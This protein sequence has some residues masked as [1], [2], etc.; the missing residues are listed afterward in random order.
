M[1]KGVIFDF[2]G[3]IVDTEKF[4]YQ[5]F[6]NALKPFGIGYSWQEYVKYYIGFDDRDAFKES[7]KANRLALPD[8]MLLD[9]IE[10]K[11]ENFKKI[12]L[13][14]VVSYP[15]VIDLVTSL[16]ENIPIAICSG[17]LYTDIEPI[18]KGLGI[19]N[20]FSCVISAENVAVSKPDPTSYKLALKSLQK[21]FPDKLIASNNIVAIEDT[22]AG[23]ASAKGAGLSV[24]AVTNSYPSD[25]LKNADSVVSSLENI[26]QKKLQDILPTI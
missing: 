12:A 16:A 1:L 23:I 14:E 8:S 21:L 20:L 4:H 3:V 6:Q 24:L 18:L 26:N 7:F 10:T 15:G 5:A 13:T 11:A 17:A 2:D 19:L 25:E 22:P 9:L